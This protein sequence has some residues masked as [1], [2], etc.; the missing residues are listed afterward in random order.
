MFYTTHVRSRPSQRPYNVRYYREN[1][2]RELARVRRRALKDIEVLHQLKQLP[3]ADSGERFASEAMDLDHR[4]PESKEFDVLKRAGSVS[5]TRLLAEVAKCD[6]VCANCHRLRTY[7]AFKDGLIRF[8]GF[9]PSATPAKTAWLQRKREKFR[10]RREE[11]MKFLE[12][13]RELPCADC[14]RRFLPVVM[15]FDHRDPSAKR[16]AMNTVA[17]RLRFSRLL[18]EM[19]K[20]DIL[21]TNCHRIRTRRRS[22]GRMRE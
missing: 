2:N 17:G 5:R 4:N 3:C 14:G 1:R 18:E 13:V 6:V 7:A 16:Y 8:P 19:A 11:Q 21:C 15:E 20:C 9:R 10:S 22:H 12:R